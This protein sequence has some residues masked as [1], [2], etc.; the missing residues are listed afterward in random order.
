MIR[1][2]MPDFHVQHIDIGK[3]AM[4]FHGIAVEIGKDARPAKMLV[5]FPDN[6]SMYLNVQQSEQWD[7]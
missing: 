3:Y 2:R 4:E 1:E 7:D 5:R 6:W